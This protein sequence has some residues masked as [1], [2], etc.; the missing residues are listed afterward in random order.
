[1]INHTP[2]TLLH[3]W[4]ALKVS[5]SAAWISQSHFK[6]VLLH[7]RCYLLQFRDGLLSQKLTWIRACAAQMLPGIHIWPSGCKL[8]LWTR[9]TGRTPLNPVT[10]SHYNIGTQIWDTEQHMT[11]GFVLLEL[12][13]HAWGLYLKLMR[14]NVSTMS[15][16][17]NCNFK[18]VQYK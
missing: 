13:C 5:Q 12:G 4:T 17:T 16:W 7:R 14:E 2:A 9:M 18:V 11:C 8:P 1:M 15:Q 3:S 10:A 6:F